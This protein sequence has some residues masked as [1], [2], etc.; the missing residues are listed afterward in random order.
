MDGSSLRLIFI[1]VPCLRVSVLNTQHESLGRH[2]S[3]QMSHPPLATSQTL[4]TRE[5]RGI[6]E[7]LHLSAYLGQRPA[8]TDQSSI[9]NQAQMVGVVGNRMVGNSLERETP[10]ISRVSSVIIP[11]ENIRPCSTWRLLRIAGMPTR[12]DVSWR[13]KERSAEK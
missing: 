10:F 7:T 9:T 12:T 13:D 4:Q 1:K 5:T 8:N 3:S 6:R 2:N 11:V